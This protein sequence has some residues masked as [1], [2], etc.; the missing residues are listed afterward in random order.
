MK[1][2]LLT[3][4]YPP[5]HGGGISTYCYFTAQML[6]GAGYAVTVFTQNESVD[7]FTISTDL[8]I[9]LIKFNSNRDGY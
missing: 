4:E 5:L 8:N 7:D 2:W 6:A 9:R 1:Y 3:T